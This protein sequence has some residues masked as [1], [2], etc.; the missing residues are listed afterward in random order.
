[1]AAPTVM[2]MAFLRLGFAQPP[3]QHFVDR[4]NASFWMSSS[5]AAAE[6][7]DYLPCRLSVAF[8]VRPGENRDQ[9]DYVRDC[10]G[11]FLVSG[12]SSARAPVMAMER[13]AAGMEVGVMNDDD[14]G[15]GSANA[16][17]RSASWRQLVVTHTA[18]DRAEL[19]VAV[20]GGV[21]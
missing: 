5:P 12:L 6:L 3:Q 2:T 11:A 20:A 1:M 15:C 14:P 19:E 13:H 17:K 4:G 7:G 9:A 18:R 21:W 16:V 8:P 10:Y